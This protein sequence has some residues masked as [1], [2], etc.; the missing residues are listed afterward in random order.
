MSLVIIN[1]TYHSVFTDDA[2][3]YPKINKALY[4]FFNNIHKSNS[5]LIIPTFT[6]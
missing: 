2:N 6:F 3:N 1:D 4:N 5:I